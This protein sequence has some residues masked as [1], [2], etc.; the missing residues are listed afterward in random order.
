VYVVEQGGRIVRVAGDGSTS[1]LL[2]ISDQVA[3]EGEQGLLSVAF[4]PDFQRSGLLYVDFTETGGDT[5]VVEYRSADGRSV[6]PDSRRELLAIEQPFANHNGGQLQFGPDG[7]LYIGTGDGG[8]AADP[9]RNAQ[10]L[11]SLL[12]KL[13]RIDPNPAGERAYSIP[14]DNPFVDVPGAEPEIFALGLRNPWRFSFDRETG[15][16]AIG[17]V[18]Q[19][20]WEE[21]DLTSGPRSAGANFGWSAFE[22]EERFNADQ[23]APDHV[24]PVL[25]YANADGD[26][27]VTGGYVVRDPELPTLYGRYLYAD[28]CRGELRSFVADPDRPATGDRELGLQVTS[29]SSFGEDQSG[30][31]YVASLEGDV[32]RL[33]PAT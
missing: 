11:G 19:D 18:G 14:A 1:T 21:V 16:L 29:P 22:G 4:A 13:L 10:D 23:E 6:D 27:S 33:E 20:S 26:C 30:R 25:T 8:S 15:A 2:D 9:E 28:F 32:F 31:I 7:L 3:A 24:P 5:R 12:G 17:D